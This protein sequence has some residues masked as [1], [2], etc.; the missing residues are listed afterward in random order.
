MINRRSFSY[1]YQNE[2]MQKA[3]EEFVNAF[4]EKPKAFGS[5]GYCHTAVTERILAERDIYWVPTPYIPYGYREYRSNPPIFLEPFTDERLVREDGQVSLFESRIWWSYRLINSL[6]ESAELESGDEEYLEYKA[7]RI[8]QVILERWN[9][10]KR[11]SMNIHQYN[12]LYEEG[13]ADYP[14]NGCK[15]L[16]KLLTGLEKEV[17][18]I[19]YLSSFEIGQEE[20][21]ESE[22]KNVQED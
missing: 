5:G 21:M 1:E 14:F 11:V 22:D 4:G 13:T 15:F 20:R 16:D 17:G 8:S 18:D 6:K 19:S 12:F 10:G 7:D 2:R 9:A 3:T